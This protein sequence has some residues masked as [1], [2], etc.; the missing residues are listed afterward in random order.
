MVIL[1]KR[2][3]GLIMIGLGWLVEANKKTDIQGDYIELQ[4]LKA[5]AIELVSLSYE[6]EQA[7]LDALSTRT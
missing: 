5:G 2:S 4:Y 6:T 7:Y 1:E 3:G